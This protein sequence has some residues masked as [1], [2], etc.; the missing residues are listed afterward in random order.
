MAHHDHL[1]LIFLF[2]VLI[3]TSCTSTPTETIVHTPIASQ[4]P[5][6]TISPTTT[7]TRKPTSTRTPNYTVTPTSTSK[8]TASPTNKPT[9][10]PLPFVDEFKNEISPLWT[11]LG[12]TPFITNGN[13]ATSNSTWLFVGNSGWDNYRIE[14][15]SEV[16]CHLC[17]GEPQSELGIRV[18][19]NANMMV[20]EWDNLSIT[21][22]YMENGVLREIPNARSYIGNL[23]YYTVLDTGMHYIITVK[24]NQIVV[25]VNG[26]KFIDLVLPPDESKKYEAGGVALHILEESQVRYFKVLPLP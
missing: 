25:S 17:P 26:S 2:F 6:S 4:K 11:I 20:L 15:I 13:L 16:F 18:Q 21:W 1:P 12:E 19:D 8:P 3:I 9:P 10:F 22:L 5:S 14:F 23:R 7:K 24:N